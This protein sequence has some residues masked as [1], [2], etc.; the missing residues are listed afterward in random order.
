LAC[1]AGDGGDVGSIPW[2]GRSSKVGNGIPLSIVAWKIPRTEEP[3][4][5]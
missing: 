5:L 4:G 2:S 1:S 3:G